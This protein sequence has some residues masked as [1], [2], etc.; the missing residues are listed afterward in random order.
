MS[1]IY[2][3]DTMIAMFTDANAKGKDSNI[4]KL[5]SIY[6]KQLENIYLTTNQIK[7]FRSVDYA[8][9]T[10]L[11]LIGSNFNVPRCN[12]YDD[13]YR[14]H[15]KFAIARGYV[16]DDYNSVVKMIAF[17]FN[18][19][20]RDIS[21]VEDYV[22]GGSASVTIDKVPAKQLN[23]VGMSIG[24]YHKLVQSILPLGVGLTEREYEGS[25]SFSSTNEVEISDTQG[26]ADDEQLLG[27]TLSEV[28]QDN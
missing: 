7:D 6:T 24:E 12:M 21:F 14:I 20:V 27:G 5:C 13:K 16:K 18:A 22:N 17:I 8:K 4:Y 1:N 2:N 9:G 3:A 26:F 11:D 19:D 25:F 15:I 23:G 28:I 10:S